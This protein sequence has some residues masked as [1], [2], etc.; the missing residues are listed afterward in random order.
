VSEF[1]LLS[2][3][4][5][6]VR[7]LQAA[8]FQQETYY[9]E[10]R[11]RWILQRGRI[12]G[13]LH[14]EDHAVSPPSAEGG[15]SFS[16]TV[17]GCFGVAEQGSIIEI[18]DSRESIVRGTLEAQ[19]GEMVP[20]FVGV[21]FVPQSG[22]SEAPTARGAHHWETL[23]RPYILA[24]SDTAPDYDWLQIAQFIKTPSGLQVDENYIPECL[25][26]NSHARLCDARDRIKLLAH[27]GLKILQDNAALNAAPQVY[28]TAAALAAS[29]GL[30][31]QSVNGQVHPRDYIDRLAGVLAA[32]R[33]Q[34]LILPRP[35]DR[36]HG[37]AE[38]QINTT[39]NY[40]SG[41]EWTLGEALR[42]IIECFQ[43]LLRLYP[44][45][46]SSLNAAVPPPRVDWQRPNIVEPATPPVAAQE[47]SYSWS[48]TR[49]QTPPAGQEEPQPPK[50]R[51]WRSG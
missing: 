25:F 1:N 50:R 48:N 8:Q 39:L 40:L 17:R 34:I 21:A 26:L 30:A 51:M 36:A 7:L 11:G 37:A 45:L 46:L 32:Q 20:L 24:A 44:P 22:D 6:S 42:Q 4:W 38:Q 15:R 31:A 16:V 3:D 27:E 23:A 14:L 10:E 19:E 47:Q 18:P 2:V 41:G 13:V 28:S 35:N 5:N 49:P 12:F 9:L 29:L 43:C 33:A